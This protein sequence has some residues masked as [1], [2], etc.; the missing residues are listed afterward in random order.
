MPEHIR[1]LVVILGLSA[2]TFL[3]AH[4][5][6]VSLGMTS[7]DFKR[8][9]N[10][11]LAATL[12]AFVASNFWVFVVAMVALLAVTRGK[13]R[14]PLALYFFLLF[15]VPPFTAALPGLGVI[16]QFF[17]LSFPRILSLLV[18]LP[19]A[20]VLWRQQETRRFGGHPADWLLLGYLA[21]QAALQFGTNTFTN[22]LRSGFYSY[23]DAFLPYYVASRSLRNMDDFRDALLSFAMAVMLM[24]PIAA[25]E[26][27]KHWLLYSALPSS[28]GMQWDSGVYVVRGDSLRAVASAWL[29]LAPQQHR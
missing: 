27:L 8:R 3:I 28:L 24:A 17:E 11:W 23:L 29:L 16:N 2:F 13:E 5:P 26:F 6:A 4:E 14:N 18:L 19:C 25:F 20:L 9:R 15:V 22:T 7:G 21:L 12:V 1:A 10:L